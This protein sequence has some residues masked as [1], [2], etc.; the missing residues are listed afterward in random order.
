[1]FK[2]AYIFLVATAWWSITVVAGCSHRP[3]A[4]NPN[5][6]SSL[7]IGTWSI[8]R[9]HSDLGLPS[10]LLKDYFDKGDRVTFKS[11]HTYT[12]YPISSK[13]SWIVDG[14]KLYVTIPHSNTMLRLMESGSVTGPD[15]LTL[16]YEASAD[17]TSIAWVPIAANRKRLFRQ[18]Y[19]KTSQSIARFGR[20]T[21][22]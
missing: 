1:M 11:D 16:H 18:S 3:Y 7:L 8:D 21:L 15:R 4:N 5:D 13:G 20:S 12:W 17:M 6:L 10:T 19:V 9:D 14:R 22:R 2:A